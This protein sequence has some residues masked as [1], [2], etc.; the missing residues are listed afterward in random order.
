MKAATFWNKAFLAALHRLPAEEA[1]IE[2]DSALQ[3]SLEHWTDESLEFVEVTRR[4][5]KWNMPLQRAATLRVPPLPIQRRR[6][7]ESS[8]KQE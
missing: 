4:Q 6:S 2:A 1:R 5:N 7:S 3:L 8:S